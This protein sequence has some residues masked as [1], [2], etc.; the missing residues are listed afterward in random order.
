MQQHA[1]GYADLGGYMEG[2]GWVLQSSALLTIIQVLGNYTLIEYFTVRFAVQELRLIYPFVRLW[3]LGFI[4]Q[5][6]YMETTT[7]PHTMAT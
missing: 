3:K 5:P 1:E 7:Y 4:L 2:I 6:P